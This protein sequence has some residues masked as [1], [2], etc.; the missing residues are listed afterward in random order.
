MTLRDLLLRIRA[1]VSA[2]RVEHE[3]DEEL[4]FHI[5]RETHKHIANGLSPA[6]ARARALARF[7]SV[8]LAADQCRDARGIGL[9]EDLTRDIVYAIRAFRRA[10]LAAVTIIATVALGLGL[11]TA[12]F[13]IYNTIL[14]R[15][16]AV[17]NPGELFVVEPRLPLSGERVPLTRADYE[18]MRRETSV[19]TDAAA[20]QS[21]VDVATVSRIDRRPAVGVLVSGNFFRMLGVQSALGRPLVPEDDA[22]F[23]GRPV[24]VLSHAGWR[25]L[26]DADPGIVG[27]H[28]I[29]NNSPFEIVGVMPDGFRGLNVTTPAYWAPLASAAQFRDVFA[30]REET[31]AIDVVGRLRRDLSPE[32]AA[33]SLGAW[34]SRARAARTGTNTSDGDISVMLTPRQGTL[35]DPA[36]E[37]LVAFAPLFFA[38]G[39][40]LLIG[41]A[42]VAN[43]LLARSLA[44]QREIGVRLSLG[45]SRR[46]IIRQL[47]TESLLLSLAAAACGL[48]VSRMILEGLLAAAITLPPPQI[49]QLIGLMNLT[50]PTPDWRVVL[51]LAA[52]ATMSAVFFGFAPA[53]QATRLD[54]VRTM[55]GDITKDARPGRAR[56]ALISLQVGASALLLICAVIFLKGA[57][58]AA[59]EP[60]AIRTNDTVRVSVANEPRRAALVQA[61]M[62]EPSVALVSSSSPPTQATI[63]TDTSTRASV[64]QLSVSSAYFDVLGVDIVRGRGFMPAERSADAG[65]V[66]VTQTVSRQLWPNGDSL[67]QQMRIEPRQP[68]SQ[69][70]ASV[71]SRTMTVIGVARDPRRQSGMSYL[72]T[73]RGVYL[74]ASLETP[75]T[76][77]M[78][79]VRGNPDEVRQVLLDRLTRVDPAVSNIITLRTLGTLQSDVLRIGFWV[80]VVLGVLALILTVSGLFSV[81]SYVVE[82]QAK[83][84]GVRM[85]L[86]AASKHVVRLILFQ[87][88]RPV[89]IGLAAGAGLAAALAI[90]LLTL[91]GASEI[92]DWVHVLDPVAYGVSVMTIV[93]SCALAVSVPALRAARIDPIAT[94]RKD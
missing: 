18:A 64:Q 31:M 81:L 15:A 32:A 80:T 6:D 59:S 87:S 30:G 9:V 29:I 36:L 17:R 39:L 73:F 26:F 45:A 2:H 67:G 84:I 20:L 50:V 79:R 70:A 55:R 56:H 42:N 3:L 23:A 71:T 66:V 93:T 54:L 94:L 90:L 75:G 78:L 60:P 89:G 76:W 62:A 40:I 34:A 4:A 63:E 21:S 5:E 35:P 7:G 12:V 13:T 24:I 28:V 27:R 82:Q 33:A 51:F 19:F 74:P 68:A 58:T 69:G 91:P 49:V 72:E 16:D 48:V 37:A 38:F 57:M 11:V 43:L 52:A 8:P 77:L 85:A 25:N 14:F 61:V 22:R 53:L 1:L 44:R 86:G 47:L 83:D 41:C 88:L 65:V 46:R 92:G 10:P